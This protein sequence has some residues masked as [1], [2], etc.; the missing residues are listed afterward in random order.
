MISLLP[1]VAYLSET[2]RMLE[3]HRALAAR[4]S[5]VRLATHGGTHENLLDVPYDIIPPRMDAARCAR[6]VQD[7]V[8]IGA[9]DQSMYSD[10]EMR[11][12][13]LAEAEYFQ[14]H[15]VR[16]AVTGFTLT[17]LLSTRLAGV[18]LVTEH[19]G[20]F[21]P[22][23]TGE[24][25]A[26]LRI[27]CDGFNRVAAS[28][29]VEPVPS[30]AALL[31]GDLTLV[32]E[33]PEVTGVPV[34]DMEAWSPGADPRYR[35]GARLRYTGPLFAHLDVPTPPGIDD[36]LDA[37][38]PVA[39][40]ALTSTGPDLVRVVVE[41]LLTVDGLR[42]LVAATVH[43]LTDLNSD[44]VFVADVLPSH[45]IMPRIALAVTAG[46]QGSVQTA[47]ASGTPLI[48]IPLQ[49]EQALN[50]SVAEKLGAARALAPDAVSELPALAKEMLATDSYRQAAVRIRDL[51]RTTDGP[52]RAAE[53]IHEL[54]EANS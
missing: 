18:R 39:Y 9:W 23:V 41:A 4:G 45:K 40:V 33:L 6:F 53:C 49:P 3:I 26:D 20:I 47:L 25:P 1:N 17:A 38:G 21:V 36:F 46:G 14:T 5:P 50:V 19:A 54:L 8:G 29:G 13:V 22:P 34:A 31:M 52:G 42:I 43:D 28:L 7:G 35:P 37:P 44:R 10:E 11:A 48:A 12:H 2:S 15:G 32:P 30:L 24:Y 16:V 51:Y 27:H